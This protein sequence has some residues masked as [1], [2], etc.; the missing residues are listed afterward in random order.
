MVGGLDVL[1]F[2]LSVLMMGCL[3]VLGVY[4][5]DGGRFH[6]FGPIWFWALRRI[7]CPLVLDFHL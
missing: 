2:M 3:T 7:S 4:G 6:L 5:F 1:V